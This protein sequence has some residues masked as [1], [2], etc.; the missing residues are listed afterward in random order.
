M[1][2]AG[3]RDWCHEMRLWSP[4]PRVAKV[5]A[6]TRR[7]DERTKY[8]FLVMAPR[9]HSPPLLPWNELSGRLVSDALNSKGKMERTLCD[10][11]GRLV[12]LRLLD[13]DRTPNNELLAT[14]ERGTL[15]QINNTSLPRVSR[16]AMVN[17]AIRG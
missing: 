12:P 13:R 1:L 11:D 3:D 7:R 15:I 9:Q 5:Q 4:T 2:A 17:P 8:S 16:E 14:A 6:L 10:S